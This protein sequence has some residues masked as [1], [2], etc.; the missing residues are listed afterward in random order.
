[1]SKV[2]MELAHS[3]QCLFYAIFLSSNRFQCLNLALSFSATYIN[4]IPYEISINF[5]FVHLLLFVTAL[6]NAHTKQYRRHKNDQSATVAC[7]ID[8]EQRCSSSSSST[9]SKQNGGVRKRK[10]CAHATF[11]PTAFLIYYN[12]SPRM[13]EAEKNNNNNNILQK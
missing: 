2:I 8:K 12:K 10:K 6:Y 9:I 13:H 5:I 4:P 1:M 11:Y 7:Y 3:T